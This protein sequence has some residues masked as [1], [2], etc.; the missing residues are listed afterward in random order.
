[1]SIRCM[2]DVSTSSGVVISSSGM[3]GSRASVLSS[4]VAASSGSFS[5]SAPAVATSIDVTSSLSGIAG[6][7]SSSYVGYCGWVF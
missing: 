5:P 1:M 7:W 4:V 2:S 3:V 6:I